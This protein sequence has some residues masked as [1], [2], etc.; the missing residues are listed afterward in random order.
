[1]K[2]LSRYNQK[3]QSGQALLFVVIAMTIALTIGINASVRTI[4][5]LSRT[6]RSDTASRALAASEGGLERFLVLPTQVLEDIIQ[7]NNC[8]SGTTYD[9]STSSCVV[10][11]GGPS[12]ILVSQAFVTVERYVPIPY[13]PFE[14]SNGA[15]KEVNFY[16]YV[17][18]SHYGNT[19]VTLCW[20]G[21]AALTYL[22][23]DSSGILEQGGLVHGTSGVDTSTTF[24]AGGPG[25][26]DYD[27]CNNVRIGTD[28]Y[29]LRLRSIGGDSTVGVYGIGEDLPLQGYVI[30]SVG[31]L[32][33]DTGV[34]ASRTIRIVRSLPYLPGSFDYA[35][36]SEGAVSK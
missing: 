10:D 18:L 7:N 12:D 33:Q 3:G 28:V 34:T 6:T 32:A 15:V 1:M 13:Y 2:K 26:G 29:G 31:R 19:D 21:N 11:F 9:S 5:S 27:N 8:P 24:T 20:S 4:T 17:N 30:T 22:S 14:L 23:Y 16:D 25:N 35:L 36:Y